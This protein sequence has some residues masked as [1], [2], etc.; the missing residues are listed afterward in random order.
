MFVRLQNGDSIE[1]DI[2]DHETAAPYIVEAGYAMQ[3][4]YRESHLLGG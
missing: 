3:D 1:S 4:C 2:E